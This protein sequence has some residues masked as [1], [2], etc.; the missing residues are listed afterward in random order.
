MSTAALRQDAAG[1]GEFGCGYVEEGGARHEGQQR[2]ILLQLVQLGDRD[3]AVCM[4][5][6]VAEQDDQTLLFSQQVLKRL[7]GTQR[8]SYNQT[9]MDQLHRQKSHSRPLLPESQRQTCK[10]QESPGTGPV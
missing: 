7:R 5:E 1:L 10:P 6:P 2:Q 3:D 9:S 8:K 4:E